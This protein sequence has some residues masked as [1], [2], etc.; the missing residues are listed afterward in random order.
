MQFTRQ[1]YN[2]NSRVYNLMELPIELLFFRHWRKRLFKMIKGIRILEVGIGTGKNINYYPADISAV[3]IDLSEGMLSKAKPIAAA[4]EVDLVQMDIEHLAFK[5]NPFDTI[6]S[7]YVF[8]SVPNP[9][10]GLK[11][12]KKVLEPNGQLLF[13]EHVLPENKL[14]AW[15]FNKLDHFMVLV[16][17]VHINRNTADNIRKAGFELIYEENLLS[18]IFKLYAAR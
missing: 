4:H 16:S 12:L 7:T 8:C 3:G 14:L 11:E 10:V 17:G 9:I 2:R 6:I 15:I 18:S 5:E 13:L 1:R